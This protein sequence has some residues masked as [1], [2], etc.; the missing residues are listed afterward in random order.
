MIDDA[1]DEV[2][3]LAQQLIRERTVNPPGGERGLA[4]TLGL[5]L[6]SDGFT[7]R[8]LD[9]GPDRS[10]L[11][12]RRQ[13]AGRREPVIFS[14]HL[15][16]VPA[17]QSDWD[18]DP[19]GGSIVDGRLYGRGAVDMKGGVAAMVV[20]AGRLALKPLEGDLLVALSADE[21]IGAQGA[22]QLVG[23]PDFPRD[24]RLIV[25]E[26]TSMRVGVA[27]KGALWVEVRFT[28]KA[29]HGAYPHEGASAIAAI[30]ASVPDVVAIADRWDRHPVL[31]PTTANL[32][33][34]GGG[35]AP[36]MVADSAWIRIDF[37]TAPG[38][39]HKALVV[40]IE[41]V[42][43]DSLTRGVRAEVVVHADRPAF[44]T[45][46]DHPLVVAAIGIVRKVDPDAGPIGL[47]Y[48]TDAAEF[49][50][51]QDYPTIILGPGD[52]EVAHKVNENIAVAELKTAVGIYEALGL[53]LLC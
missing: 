34:V 43:A 42:L 8:K 10:S 6:Q 17:G 7:V 46:P 30:L 28:G 48:Y 29:A 3:A 22:I 26:P 5:R 16:T 15:D 25:G 40:E 20:A 12:A 45:P 51:S 27:E 38:R 19:F 49:R 23:D 11:L 9:H 21:E 47:S 37:R 14:G 39:G 1:S 44:A 13:G 24:G 36:N 2:L 33:M 18:S 41:A 50:R 35:S 53:E 52:P 31:G 32:A 4:E